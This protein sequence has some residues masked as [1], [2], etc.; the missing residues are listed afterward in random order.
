[1][2]LEWGRTASMF[3]G[4]EASEA[5]RPRQTIVLRAILQMP[6]QGLRARMRRCILGDG[7]FLAIQ[8][9]VFTVGQPC[10][11]RQPVARRHRD[12]SKV[13]QRVDVGSEKQAVPHVVGL[14]A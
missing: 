3:R 10:R 5:A 6:G 13:K 9:G 2:C 14:D 11:D 8:G 1:M 7:E 12:Q 4:R